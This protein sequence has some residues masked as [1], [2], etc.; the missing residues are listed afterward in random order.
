[1]SNGD[2]DKLLRQA[3]VPER[4]VAY[5]DAFPGRVVRSLQANVDGR[6]PKRLGFLA[7]AAAAASGG[8]A[9][10]LVWLWLGRPQPPVSNDALKDGSALSAMLTRFPRR[11][12]AVIRDKEGIHTL[13]SSTEDVSTSGPIW[14]EIREGDSDRVIA[15][16]SGQ[17]VP[18]GHGDA[19][20]LLDGSGHVMLIGDAIFWSQEASAGLPGGMML[21]AAQIPAAREPRRP[22]SPL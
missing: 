14:I 16:F 17:K 21:R 4:P 19:I 12:R 13:V 6:E 11:L 2:L 1:M 7:M 3:K 10:L 20:V 18:T 5:W 9:M 8:L 22:A 15:T